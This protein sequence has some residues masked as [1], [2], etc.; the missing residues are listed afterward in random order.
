MGKNL[1]MNFDLLSQEIEDACRKCF[2][3]LRLK[4]SSEEICG[5]A[6]YSDAGGLSVGPALNSKAHLEKVTADDPEDSIY[7]KW[8]PG[9]WAYESEC[10]ELFAKISNILREESK[11]LKTQQQFLEFRNSVYEACVTSLEKLIEDGFL[12]KGDEECVVVF[13]V[14]DAEEP[15]KEIEWIERLNL[16]NQSD[17]FL[18]WISDL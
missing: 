12:S 3:T 1:T 8:S 5:Y 4:Y 13:T 7:Y 6:I 17:E 15:K 18:D 10:S 9:E 16:K 11:N 2:S 14:F